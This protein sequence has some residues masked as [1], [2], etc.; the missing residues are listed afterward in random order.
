M[1]RTLRRGLVLALVS[2]AT[3]GT[4]GALAKPLLEAGWSPTAAVATRVSVGAVLLAGPAAYA[5][6]GRWH[7]LRRGWPS[8]L[9]FGLF[10][11]AMC[12]VAYFQ[13]VARV[14]VGVALLLEYLGVILVVGWLWLRRGQTP[15]PL[16]VLGTGLAAV[17]LTLVLD[18]L[19][20]VQLDLL[21]VAWGLL[22]A[23]GL[24]AYFVISGE[25]RS[26][27]PP[28]AVAAGGLGVGAIT[29]G[30]L[31]ATGWVAWEWSTA[32]V[33]LAGRAVPVWGPLLGLGLVAAALAYAL[34]VAAARVLGSK[35]ASFVGLTEVLF[36]VLFAWLLLGEVLT[37]GQL[38]GGLFVLAG[39]VAV[40]LD[41]RP[42]GTGPGGHVASA[43]PE[44]AGIAGAGPP[45]G[46]CAP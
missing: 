26:G 24:A 11:V 40:K 19:G 45:L 13:A 3:F 6:R 22:A 2:A 10:A 34:G 43:Q 15:R 23:T 8:I 30:V 4:S 7:T 28:L 39:V 27:V 38:L 41:E 17:G 42:A 36:S 14:P 12:Q 16:T 20:S 33:V 1:D 35:M 29:L 9:L 25:D 44:P 21:G 37:P 5:L 31:G 46:H 32:D 18:V